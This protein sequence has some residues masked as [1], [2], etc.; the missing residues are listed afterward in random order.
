MDDAATQQLKALFYE[1]LLR[2]SDL[3]RCLQEEKTSLIDID[4]SRL[5]ELARE[6]EETCMAIEEIRRKMQDLVPDSVEPR[7]S[8][9]RQV[10]DALPLEHRGEFQ[11]LY[12]TVNRLKGDIEAMRKENMIHVDQSLQFLDEIISVMAGVTPNHANYSERSVPGKRRNMVFL[13]REV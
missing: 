7:P 1:K 10:L 13:N 12:R 2:Y 3:R 8:S 9:I 5:W 11:E 6:K 4:V